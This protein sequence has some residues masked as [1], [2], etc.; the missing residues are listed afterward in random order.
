MFNWSHQFKALWLHCV[1]QSAKSLAPPSMSCAPSEASPGSLAVHSCDLA[2]RSDGRT[3]A[4]FVC[5]QNLYM[6][7]FYY[8]MHA[9]IHRYIYIYIWCKTWCIPCHHVSFISSHIVSYY[10]KLQYIISYYTKLH[11]YIYCFKIIYD[12]KYI[13][14][15][16]CSYVY[17]TWFNMIQCCSEKRLDCG[18]KIHGWIYRKGPQSTCC[19]GC[20]LDIPSGKLT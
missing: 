1:W 8:I 16:V 17:R 6:H 12:Y 2:K 11:I 19:M 18:N 7:C 10:V 5:L 15:R 20:I 14:T 3:T 9:W 13:H 4:V